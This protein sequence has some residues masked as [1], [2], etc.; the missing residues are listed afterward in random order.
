MSFEKR[1]SS[2]ILELSDETSRGIWRAKVPGSGSG[3]NDEWKAGGRKLEHS[4]SFL[5]LQLNNKSAKI[6][7]PSP[8]LPILPAFQFIPKGRVNEVEPDPEMTVEGGEDLFLAMRKPLRVGAFLG[9]IPIRGIWSS[10]SS[11]NL[12]TFS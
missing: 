7:S 5:M 11:K 12:Q 9:L 6:P 10:S 4:L 3:E 1:R 2:H 8:M